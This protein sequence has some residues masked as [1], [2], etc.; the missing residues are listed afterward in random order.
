MLRYIAHRLLTGLAALTVLIFGFYVM[1]WATYTPPPCA[2]GSPYLVDCVALTEGVQAH[3][4]SLGQ[5]AFD[6]MS[7]VAT[8]VVLLAIWG[9]REWIDGTASSSPRIVS[10]SASCQ[11][12]LRSAGLR[13]H[14]R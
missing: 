13:S 3:F 1:T 7:I 14:C 5:P 8:L 11:L 4:D 6:S 2:P 12:F 10:T 9:A